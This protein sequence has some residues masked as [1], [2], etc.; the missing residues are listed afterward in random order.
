LTPASLAALARDLRPVVDDVLV[1]GHAGHV[2]ALVGQCGA[3]DG[4][5]VGGGDGTIFEVLQACDRGRQRLG[6]LPFGRGNSLARD[7]RLDTAARAIHSISAGVDRPIDLLDVTLRSEGGMEW[8]GVSASNV[9]TGYPAA[10]A[11]DAARWR[12]LR[13]QSYTAAGLLARPARFTARMRTDDGPAAVASLTGLIISNSRY[14]GP[15]LGFPRADLA[16]GVIHA[17]ELRSN[18]MGQMAHNLSAVTGLR[19][20]EPGVVRD[21]RSLR[22]RLEAPALVKIDGELRGGIREIDVRVLPRAATF[23]VPA[24]RHA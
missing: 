6:V 1:S 20:Y 14:V 12:R 13:A 9:A 10:V 16:D 21:V 23:R 3:A 15:F 17:M 8:R 5:L 22:L 2:A 7:L 24:D 19:F 11:R 18:W 4:I